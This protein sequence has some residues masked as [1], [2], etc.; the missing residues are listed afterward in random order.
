[1]AS[2]FCLAFFTKWVLTR[3]FRIKRLGPIYKMQIA[4]QSAHIRAIGTI[5]ILI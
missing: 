4:P 2:L 3:S 1:M 5:S